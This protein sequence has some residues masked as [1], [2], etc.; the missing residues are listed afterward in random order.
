MEILAIKSIKYICCCSINFPQRPQWGFFVFICCLLWN[1]QKISLLVFVLQHTS[2]NTQVHSHHQRTSFDNFLIKNAN[3]HTHTRTTEAAIFVICLFDGSFCCCWVCACVDDFSTGQ[4]DHTRD[5]K[6]HAVHP[7]KILIVF[8]K[9]FFLF[10]QISPHFFC[11]RC[12][13]S[14]DC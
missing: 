1:E 8:W 5:G 12:K 2:S 7:G 11:K 4:W 13:F 14:S 10:F 6:I 3:I 9:T